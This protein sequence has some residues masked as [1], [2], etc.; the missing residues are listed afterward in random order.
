MLIAICPGIAY[1]FTHL[2]HALFCELFDSSPL[3]PA[4][5][6]CYSSA[7]LRWHSIWNYFESSARALA[8]VN[9]GR[10]HCSF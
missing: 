1:E 8:V 3:S 7:S 2:L 4:F 5:G 10:G 6:C 9:H